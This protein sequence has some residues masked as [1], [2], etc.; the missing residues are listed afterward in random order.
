MDVM[1]EAVRERA[2][3]VDLLES[4]GDDEWNAP[5]LCSDW[6]VKDVV[7]HIVSYDGLSPVGAAGLAVRGRLWPDRMNA[8]GVARLAERAPADLVRHLRENPRPSGFTAALGGAVALVDTLIHQQ[9]VR[10]PLGRPREVPD[11]RV[12]F[13]LGFAYAA[14]VVRG[15]W[16]V[17]GARV[18]APRVDWEA[19][20]GPVATGEP[21]SVLMVL[22][23]RRGVLDELSGPGVE[24]LRP[25][26]G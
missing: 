6:S 9:D 17:R 23:G 24:R 14:P 2:E 15:F 12:R 13:A 5:S 20:R 25:R 18:G 10:R 7:A 21:E 11:E 4:L 26:L 3:L 1:A 19:G 22:A 16:N 8:V